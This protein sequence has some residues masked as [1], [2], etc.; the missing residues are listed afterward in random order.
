MGQFNDVRI[1]LCLLFC[2]P[3]LQRKCHVFFFFL[4]RNFQSKSKAIR[5]L[6]AEVTL[7]DIA[8]TPTLH[9]ESMRNARSAKVWHDSSKEF[10]TFESLQ[11]GKSPIVKGGEKNK[12]K[13]MPRE[14]LDD[15]ALGAGR[16]G[17]PWPTG[18]GSCRPDRDWPFLG[19]SSALQLCHHVSTDA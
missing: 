19:L 12:E 3:R 5:A 17:R 7:I 4:S 1:V 18:A 13:K 9:S 16:A 2:G 10:G 6:H 15:A 8:F 14:R 11:L